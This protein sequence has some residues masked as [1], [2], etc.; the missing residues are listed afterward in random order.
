M[1]DDGGR[2]NEKRRYWM[3]RNNSAISDRPKTQSV[4]IGIEEK[5]CNSRCARASSG[6]DKALRQPSL[7]GQHKKHETTLPHL[8]PSLKSDEATDEN[9]RLSTVIRV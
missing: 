1:D 2:L 6:A 4:G 7:A 9:G 5:P 8:F 3:F